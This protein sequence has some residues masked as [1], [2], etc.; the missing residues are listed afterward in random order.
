MEARFWAPA[1]NLS[2]LIDLAFINPRLVTK[3]HSTGA[4][5][6]INRPLVR[7]AFIDTP[8]REEYR[9]PRFSSNER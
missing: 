1:E 5:V 9:F 4:P 2:D 8:R 6:Q 7:S 3:P